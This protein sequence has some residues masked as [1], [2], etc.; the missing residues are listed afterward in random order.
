MISRGDYIVIHELYAKGYSIRKISRTLKIDRKTVT[1]R[2]REASYKSQ[3]RTAK[4]AGV[5]APYKNYILEFIK[6]SKHRIPYPVIL[7]DIMARG[8]EGSR[9]TLQHFL[10]SEYKKLNLTNDPI[11]RFETAPGEQMQVDWTT[12]RYGRDPIY[13]FVATLGYSRYSFVYFVNNM[14][15]DTLIQ[16]HERAFL[17]FNGV[18]KTILYDNMKAV[19]EERNYYGKEQHKYNPKLLDLSKQYGFEIRLCKPYRA[20]TKGKVERFN[21]YLKS[22]FYRPLVIKLSDAGLIATHQIL[23]NYINSW[24]I[25]ANDRI[26][27]T[28]NKNPSEQFSLEVQQLLKYHI[29]TQLESETI[30]P[31]IVVN[32]RYKELPLTT[33]LQ[34]TLSQYDSLLEIAV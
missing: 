16:C 13:A 11:V 20:K 10:T 5:L 34:P 7:E 22:N 9:A 6:K 14:E 32:K 28:T 3:T 12:I 23:N 26:H 30:N 21:S 27:G 24:L 15:A 2:L 1:R 18:T 29:N 17:Y 31:T 8:Y 33:V 25:R 19:V 4:K